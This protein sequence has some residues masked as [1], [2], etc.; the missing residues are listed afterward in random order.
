MDLRSTRFEDSKLA[1]SIV[2][3]HH[4]GC[5]MGLLTVICSTPRVPVGQFLHQ[6]PSWLSAWHV[7]SMSNNRT[8]QKSVTFGTL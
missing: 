5:L 7:F 1:A 6:S 3:V 2:F 4:V 8:S